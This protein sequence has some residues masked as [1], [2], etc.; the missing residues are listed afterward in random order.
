MDCTW[1]K[2]IQYIQ[3]VIPARVLE[4]EDPKLHKGCDI[5]EKEEDMH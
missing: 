3:W 4:G 1:D 2:Q 5:R